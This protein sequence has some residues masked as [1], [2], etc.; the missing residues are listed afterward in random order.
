MARIKCFSQLKRKVLSWWMQAMPSTFELPNSTTQ[1]QEPVSST[2]EGTN[3]Y[4][5]REGQLFTNGELIFSQEGTTQGDP[6][7]MVR[8][9]VA[10][11]PLI[12]R[13]AEEN[14]K[15]VW[16]AD[17]VSDGGK[18]EYLRKL[19]DN[20]S[21][22]GPE[23]G[24]YPNASKTCVI[25]KEGKCDEAKNSFQRTGVAITSEGKRHL[26]SPIRSHSYEYYVKEE[27]TG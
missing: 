10:I 26:G 23:Y 14:V 21:Q 4:L 19:R 13:L 11:T 6:L 20:L 27:I 9:A 1:H 3:Q 7:A 8:Y 18:F 17:D 15:Q 25:V 16:F 22:I 24:Y 12:H 5:Q 2:H